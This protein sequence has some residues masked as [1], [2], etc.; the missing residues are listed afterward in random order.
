MQPIK[1]DPK[2]Y[3]VLR[4]IYLLAKQGNEYID[5]YANHGHRNRAD[6][7]LSHLSYGL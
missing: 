4:Y 7:D 6:M 5:T 2:N 1:A 3:L